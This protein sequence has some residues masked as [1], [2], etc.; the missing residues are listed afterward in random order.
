MSTPSWLGDF[1]AVVML[2]VAGYCASRLVLARRLGKH[3]ELDTDAGHVIMGVSMAGMLTVRLHTLPTGLWEAVFAAAAV[4]FA[5]GLF[6]R[7]SLPWQCRQPAPHLLECAAM[8]YMF[9]ALPAIAGPVVPHPAGSAMAMPAQAGGAPVLALA[10]T[11]CLLGYAAWQADRFPALGV[12]S[13]GATSG[14]G[15]AAGGTSGA[16]QCLPVLAPKCSAVCKLAMALTMSYML[17]L[18]L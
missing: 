13:A 1:L 16:P 6:R 9:F 12:A 7:Q 17:I 3:T 2:S 10:M 15:A 5:I 11:V 18:M 14:A 8:L 4:W